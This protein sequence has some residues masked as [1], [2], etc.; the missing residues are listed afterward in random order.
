MRLWLE[1]S[2]I[3]IDAASGD[4]RLLQIPGYGWQPTPRTW[5][6]PAHPG[7]VGLA[8][9]VIGAELA[10][11]EHLL[12]RAYRWRSKLKQRKGPRLAAPRI[13]R[14]RYYLDHGDQDAE[15]ADLI[16]SREVTSTGSRFLKH[17]AV[18]ELIQQ[19]FLGGLEKPE[20][21][22]I[23]DLKS[24]GLAGDPE[25]QQSEDPRGLTSPDVVEVAVG[26]SPAINDD[27]SLR[28]QIQSIEAAGSGD[29]WVN[30]VL[31]LLRAAARGEFSIGDEGPLNTAPK[32]GSAIKLA[33][34]IARQGSETARR[35]ACSEL[36]DMMSWSE[37]DHLLIGLWV[38]GLD[39]IGTE[40]VDDR[41]LLTIHT[42]ERI[43][44]DPF[45]SVSQLENILDDC[46]S[47]DQTR[48]ALGEGR[49]QD[50][51]AALNLLAQC[52]PP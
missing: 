3:L 46:D 11:P 36:T 7:V 20:A 38:A 39:Y 52:C 5:E 37:R 47:F 40:T 42:A 45:D 26:R 30:G 48:T 18:L 9:D 27:A 31:E 28:S 44:Q 12:A 33:A 43:G 23:T 14:N 32:D 8:L 16:P 19:V 13:E 49:T 2:K 4:T 15:W 29:E 1:D 41:A 17:P 35:K 34:E 21:A 50:Y 10:A 24:T 22:P 25:Q 51:L 6:F